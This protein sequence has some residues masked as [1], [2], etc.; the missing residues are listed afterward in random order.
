MKNTEDIRWKQRFQVFEKAFNRYKEAVE[1]NTLNELERNGLIQRFEYSIE[2]T[3][4]VLGDF[5]TEKGFDDVNFPKD[6][7]RQAFQS[8]IISSGQ[9]LIHALK[10]RNQLSHDYDFD[11]FTRYEVLIKNDFFKAIESV[12]LF[13]K[14]EFDK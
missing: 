5:L 6:V 9:E 14:N 7:I 13:L 3:W 2:L 8:G 1:Q 12:Y 4:K 11:K 10:I